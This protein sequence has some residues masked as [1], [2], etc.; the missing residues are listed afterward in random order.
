[1]IN[2]LELVVIVLISMAITEI[3]VK[4]LFNKEGKQK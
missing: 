1:M 3:R 2:V 4:Q